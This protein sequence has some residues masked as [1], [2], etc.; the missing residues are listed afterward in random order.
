MCRAVWQAETS[1]ARGLDLVDWSLYTPRV[2]QV[3]VIPGVS[4]RE[5]VD[6]P[7]FHDS[8]ARALDSIAQP[9][10]AAE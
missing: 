2:E 5:I 7:L 4:H 9:A 1:L 10:L 8:F 3:E 6:S